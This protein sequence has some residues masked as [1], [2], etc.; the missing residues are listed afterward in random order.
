[1]FLNV[2]NPDRASEAHLKSFNQTLN[3]QSI[4][5]LLKKLPLS[6]SP[7]FFFFQYFEDGV[8]PE[9]HVWLLHST[10]VVSPRFYGDLLY[11]GRGKGLI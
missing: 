10:Q 9:F 6:P 1:M 2:R 7:L 3:S 4:P 5:D 8:A 11:P